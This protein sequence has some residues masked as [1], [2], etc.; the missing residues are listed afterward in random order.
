METNP[1][2]SAFCASLMLL[3]FM[4]IAPAAGESLAIET[5]PAHN[6]IRTTDRRLAG[7]VSEGM[8][9]SPTFRS[10]VDRLNDSDV[11]VYLRCDAA[12]PLGV[13]GRMSFLASSGGFRYVVI[14]VSYLPSPARQVAILGHELQ[15]AVEIAETPAI[16]DPESLAHEYTATVGYRTFGVYA[17]R[18]TFDSDAANQVGTRVLREMTGN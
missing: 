3:A 5:A 7:L 18:Q 6:Q 10:L 8:R 13:D 12:P 11:V 15:H 2:R 16:V 17:A 1:L 9:T 14:R 4:P